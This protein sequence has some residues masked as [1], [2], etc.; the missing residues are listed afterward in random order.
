[1]RILFQCNTVYQLL[2]AIKL[3]YDFFSTDSCDILIS[4]IM[5]NSDVIAD[6]IKKIKLFDNVIQQEIK[7]LRL[8]IFDKLL[9]TKSK[10]KR[11]I[12]ASGD[13]LKECY[14][15]FLFSNPSPQNI[16]IFDLLREKNKKVVI[17]YYEDGLSTYSKHY[18]YLYYK[19]LKSIKAIFGKKRLLLKSNELF[20][21]DDKYFDWTPKQKIT[22]IPKDFSEDLIAKL[23]YIF[24]YQP[25]VLPRDCKTIFFEEGFYGDGKNVND[26]EIIRKCMSI[27]G[28]SGFYV[29]NHPRNRVNR[30]EGSSIK[31]LN[32]MSIPWELIVIN[33]KTRIQNINLVSISSATIFTPY[34]IFGM[35]PHCYSCMNLINDTSYLFDYI[36][37]VEK[38]I[39]SDVDS[40]KYFDDIY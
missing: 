21:F 11:I 28:Q 26:I 39:I 22:C 24:E 20:V 5:N 31:S 1:M 32:T 3:K 6:N 35:T 17:K 29:K 15:M 36:P 9:F 18:L 38:K 12:N 8:T 4:D 25:D 34:I 27:F 33:N 10:Y 19:N 7:Q 13:F 30:F 40:I 2:V 16:A 14:D 37:D 23:N